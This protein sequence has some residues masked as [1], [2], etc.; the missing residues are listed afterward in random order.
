[1][2]ELPGR[3]GWF[4]LLVLLAPL[5]AYTTA[6]RVAGILVEDEAADFWMVFGLLH[7]DLMF[8]LGCALF[9]IG[10]FA[11]FRRGVPRIL[12]AAVLH[13]TAALIVIVSTCAYGYLE[14]TGT[15]LDYS[16]VSYYLA[17]P[18]EATG[19]VASE[20]S[21]GIWLILSGAVS[22]AVFGPILLLVAW[23][24]VRSGNPGEEDEP[25][26][27]EVSE[28]GMTRARFITA[29]IGAGAGILLFRES[30]FPPSAAGQG[31]FVSRSPVSNLVATRIEEGEMEEAA[32][33]VEEVVDL[34]QLRF[35]STPRTRKRHIAFI[36]LESTRERSTTPYN[37][38]LGTMPYLAELSK[39]SL[40][41][42]RAYTTT[43]HTSKAMTSLNAGLYPHPDTDIIESQPGGVPARSL[44]M[45]LAEH[46]Y[47]SAWFQSATETFEDRRQHVANFGYDHFAAFEQM[48]TEGFEMSNYLGYEDDIMLGPSREWLEENAGSPTFVMYLGVTP[49]HEYRLIGRYGTKNFANGSDEE[50]FDRY[51]NNVYYD[52]FWTKNIIEQ[53]RELGLYEDTIFIIYGDHGEAFGEHG[54]KGHDGVP[55][56]EGLR[57][58]FVVHD[59]QNFDGGAV[60]REP[61]QL[62]DIPPTIADM[63]GFE[64]RG[65]NYPGD[66]FIRPMS[67]DRVLRFS[68]RPDLV[69]MA[70]IEGHEKYI[71]HYGKQ[72]EE[73]YDLSRDPTEQNNL[74]GRAGSRKLTQLRE[75]L[76]EWH[77]KSAA[78][79]DRSA[80][81]TA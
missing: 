6:F 10:A 47:R 12:A 37:K 33:R 20:S 49:H 15:T 11:V 69:S 43:P 30:L 61:I 17:T 67:G 2:R 5:F 63:L 65:G 52:D 50:M 9:W 79:Y 14:T 54:V 46:G 23:T 25:V 73:Y 41:V 32:G 22:Y 44:P 18:E 64:V 60:L 71:Y 4:Y 7:S 80:D 77:A 51:L 3:D 42:E 40:L 24:R 70:R 78:A 35:E 19:A 57:V 56:E 68:C 58:P 59:P 39:N 34:S 28:R 55:Y 45:L 74:A 81:K 27:E 38:D 16:V 48:P 1:M 75:D 29:G 13:V 76:L 8:G 66:S 36:H 53:Y 26:R 62:T 31:R 21:A 72:P